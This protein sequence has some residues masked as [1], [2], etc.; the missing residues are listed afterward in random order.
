MDSK[1]VQKLSFSC[2]GLD[3]S[4]NKHCWKIGTVSTD[5]SHVFFF[6][7]GVGG[8]FFPSAKEGGSSCMSVA[9]QGPRF[10]KSEGMACSA[11]CYTFNIETFYISI[12]K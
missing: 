3:F 11:L 5:I 2:Y 10:V 9:S 12:I 6:F 1:N 4:F 7:C 8:L